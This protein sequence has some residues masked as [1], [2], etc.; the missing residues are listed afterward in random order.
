M[1]ELLFGICQGFSI[2]CD[3]SNEFD[4]DHSSSWKVGVWAPMTILNTDS[5]I[6]SLGCQAVAP[7]RRIRHRHL[8]TLYIAMGR[9][10]RV[11]GCVAHCRR[12]LVAHSTVAE[13]L[14]CAFE[15]ADM[16]IPP[17]TVTVSISY[18]SRHVQTVRC[19]WYFLN[20]V[21]L[22]PD[23]PYY[24]GEDGRYLHSGL[25][26]TISRSRVL[27]PEYSITSPSP[28][29]QS[30]LSCLDTSVSWHLARH[31]SPF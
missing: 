19:Q 12:V 21:A 16:I 1:K 31:C 6:S 13:L 15:A 14:F 5:S 11:S 25:S 23:M 2:S 3:L 30:H 9:R 20:T 10:K 4:L 28:S 8:I 26:A 22:H 18:G 29:I 17:V 24:Y 7:P 27:I